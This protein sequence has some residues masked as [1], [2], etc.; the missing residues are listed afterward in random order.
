MMRYRRRAILLSEVILLLP[1]IAAV[2]IVAFQ[3]ANQAMRAHG[4]ERQLMADEAIM[5]DLVR[6]IQLD[7]RRADQAFVERGEAGT[8]L[9]FISTGRT[10]WYRVS[11]DHVMRSEQ[12]NGE[13]EQT[14][15]KPEQTG[16]VPVVR[17]GWT[18]ARTRVDFEIEA[19]GSSPGMVWISLTIAAPLNRGP[20]VERRLSA[21]AP[22]GR[23]G[24][25]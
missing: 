16:D 24:A 22:V 10:V 7:A 25:L 5:R 14:T 2:F 1:V 4:R 15:S 8:E 12:A 3:L 18:L 17:Y 9:Q 11:D 23:G 6:R 21:A 13:P 19:I 20:A